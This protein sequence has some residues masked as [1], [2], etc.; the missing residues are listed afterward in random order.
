MELLAGGIIL[1][2]M[3]LFVTSK[4]KKADYKESYRLGAEIQSKQKE[5]Q[6]LT[7]H[8][9][10]RTLD[11]STS[12]TKVQIEVLD[13]YQESNIRI[14]VDIIEDLAYSRIYDYQEIIAYIENQRNYWK[15]ENTKKPFKRSVT[16]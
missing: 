13:I 10:D 14:P 2:M 9:E 5:L 4:T 6:G 1:F 8:V 3:I 11:R 7:Q 15:L 12:L 16:K